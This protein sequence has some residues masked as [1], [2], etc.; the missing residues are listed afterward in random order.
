MAGTRRFTRVSLGLLAAGL[1]FGPFVAVASAQD[2][3]QGFEFQIDPPEEMQPFEIAGPLLTDAGAEIVVDLTDTDQ[4]IDVFTG[5]I[6][7]PDIAPGEPGDLDL[8]PGTRV[9]DIEPFGPDE[10]GDGLPDQAN[11]TLGPNAIAVDTSVETLGGGNSFLQGHC[12]GLAISYGADD[13]VLDAALGIGAAGD[14]ALIDIEGDNAGERAFTESNPFQVRP[15]GQVVYFGFLPYTGGDGPRDHMWEITTA[16]I[17]LDS[18]GDDNPDGNNA[19]AGIVDLEENIPAAARFTGV[20]PV[21]GWFFA[22]N[23]LFCI[24]EGWVEFT[25]PF[26]LFTTPGAIAAFM[27]LGGIAGL[28]FNSRPAQTFRV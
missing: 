12:G 24:A 23:G 16:G 28:L 20:F 3:D 10:D 14:G 26:P 6:G 4:L 13:E 18:G 25:G 15:D 9:I 1:A 27:A 17:S 7:V 5:G 11:V 8:P 2:D 19:N 21:Q 22:P